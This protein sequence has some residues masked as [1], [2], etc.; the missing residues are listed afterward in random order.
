M[1]AAANIKEIHDLNQSYNLT[2]LRIN[3]KNYQKKNAKISIFEIKKTKLTNI[4]LWNLTKKK[5]KGYEYQRPPKKGVKWGLS[6]S[7]TS[8]ST[9]DLMDINILNPINTH[10]TWV[11]KAKCSLIIW[12][13]Y[14]NNY[15]KDISEISITLSWDDY[16]ILIC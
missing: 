2:L 16:L 14:G 5:T 10:V 11:F 4:G 13:T 3:L 6:E 12:H 8:C 9:N 1:S 7:S 15:L